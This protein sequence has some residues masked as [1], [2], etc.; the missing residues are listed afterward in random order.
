MREGCAFGDL[1]ASWDAS[2]RPAEVY[3]VASDLTRFTCR[4]SLLGVVPNILA[5]ERYMEER[6]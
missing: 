6:R 5:M 1:R 3:G 4:L 2:R